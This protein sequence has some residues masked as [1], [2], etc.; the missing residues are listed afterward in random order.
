VRQTAKNIYGKHRWTSLDHHQYYV[1][2]TWWPPCTLCKCRA[3]IYS[4]HRRV[5]AKLTIAPASASLSFWQNIGLLWVYEY[6]SWRRIAA[7]CRTILNI[8]MINN[9]TGRTHYLL[10]CVDPI[11]S[12]SAHVVLLH[13]TQGLISLIIRRS[14]WC[15]VCH[16][17]DIGQSGHGRPR[18]LRQLGRFRGQAR[19]GHP[20][21]LLLA[22]RADGIPVSMS[23]GTIRNVIRPIGHISTID[24]EDDIGLFIWKRIIDAANIIGLINA[25]ITSLLETRSWSNRTPLKTN[26]KSRGPNSPKLYY[27]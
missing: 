26:G 16:T 8:V 19:S 27:K 2:I 9:E 4:I 15:P 21:E 25:W 7:C 14:M 13:C 10:V 6:I 11:C 18:H 20:D 3:I 23:E 1:T 12:Q 22:I 5:H 24:V 17:L